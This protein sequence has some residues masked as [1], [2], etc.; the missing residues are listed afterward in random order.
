[1]SARRR[2]DD[3]RIHIGPIYQARDTRLEGAAELRGLHASGSGISPG[4]GNE[5][6]LMHV[7]DDVSSVP[8]AMQAGTDESDTDLGRLHGD[9]PS[10]QDCERDAKVA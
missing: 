1:M 8:S 6:G 4:E 7:S 2:D 3:N 10:S 9:A 5:S